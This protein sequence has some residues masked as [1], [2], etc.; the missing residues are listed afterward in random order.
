MRPAH[1]TIRPATVQRTAAKVLEQTLPWNDYGRI[2]TTKRII[3]LI[4]LSAALGSSLAAVVRRFGFGCSHE[5][6][7]KRFIPTS[8]SC[9]N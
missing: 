7:A 1:S 8:P 4:V 5:T 2:L 3:D 6:D 9:P